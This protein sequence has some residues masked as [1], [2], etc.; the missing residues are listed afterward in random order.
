[1]LGRMALL[2]ATNQ[3]PAFITNGL[4]L[5][6]DA[7]N[8]A[9]YSGSGSNWYDISGNSRNATLINSPTYSSANGGSL[10]FDGNTKYAS[11]PSNAAFNLNTA[12]TISV[13]VKR[14]G[15]PVQTDEPLVHRE[16]GSSPFGGWVLSVP[17]ATLLPYVRVRNSSNVADSLTSSTAIS[18]SWVN[19]VGIFNSPVLRLYLNG[20][21]VGSKTSTVTSVGTTSSSVSI[22]GTGGGYAFNGN[23]AQAAIYNRELSALEVFQNFDA[24]RGRFGI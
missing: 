14:N 19:I 13:W 8:A 16:S 18:S 21:A 17:T 2:A 1:M 5:Q 9:S 24:L 4:V 7:G 10:V 20:N 22:G 23:I 3:P 11:V 12:F 6:L 15:N